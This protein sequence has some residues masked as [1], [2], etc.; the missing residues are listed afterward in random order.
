MTDTT[1]VSGG[2][3]GPIHVAYVDSGCRV[4]GGTWT[5]QYGVAH[6]FAAGGPD[7]GCFAGIGWLTP[8]DVSCTSPTGDPGT[9]GSYPQSIVLRDAKGDV[10]VPFAFSVVCVAP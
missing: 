4:V 8:G 3:G 9:P 6:D 2:P 7:D 10:S 1:R 5:D